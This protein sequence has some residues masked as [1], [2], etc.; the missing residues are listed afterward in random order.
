[1]LTDDFNNPDGKTKIIIGTDTILEGISLEKNSAVAYNCM[2]DWNPTN[3][4][5]K[6]GRPSVAGF[7]P[8]EGSRYRSAVREDGN[9]SRR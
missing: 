2:M 9:N 7:R 5:Q 8:G 3:T 4:E 6:K 1:M